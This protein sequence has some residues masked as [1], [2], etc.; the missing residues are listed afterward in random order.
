MSVFKEIPA[1]EA[2]DIF[3]LIGDDWM[4][5]SAAREGTVNTMTANWGCAGVLW[6]KPVCICFIRPQRHTYGFVEGAERLS[7]SF[8]DKEYRPALTYCGRNSGRDVDK[9][10]ETGLTPAFS[11]EVPYIAEAKLVLLC[12]KLYADDLRGDK[13]IVES[14]LSNYTEKD[15]HRFYVCEIE[16]VLS[17]E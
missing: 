10:A 5:I 3:K 4:L 7:M 1:P 8:F 2:S 14:L 13:F 17:R 15:F 12:R 9:F 6:N 11:G 16:K